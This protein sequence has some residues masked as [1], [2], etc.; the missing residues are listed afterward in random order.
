MSIYY[1]FIQ[2]NRGEATRMGSKDSG[3]IAWAQSHDARITVNIDRSMSDDKD[4]ADIVFGA[5]HSTSYGSRRLEIRDLSAFVAALDTNDPKIM[6][7]W[8]RV[9]DNIMRIDREA[10]TAIQRKQKRDERARKKEER[11]RKQDR[12]QRENIVL[13]LKPE[14]KA[15]LER[16]GVCEWDSEGN[17]VSLDWI[18]SYRNN[19]R[20]DPGTTGHV[21][22]TV[23]MPDSYFNNDFDLTEGRWVLSFAPTDLGIKEPS[24]MGFGYRIHESKKEVV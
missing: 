21:M 12:M 8:K 10:K 6:A 3:F 17:P 18:E 2:G 13:L 24:M 7:A 23:K 15:R 11:E 22:I 1:G 5:G 20:Y 4:A 19:L 16:L 14:E 9:T